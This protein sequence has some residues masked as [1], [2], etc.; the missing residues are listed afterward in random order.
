MTSKMDVLDPSTLPSSDA[1]GVTFDHKSQTVTLPGGIVSV[2]GVTVVTGG[3]EMTWGSC[4][5]ALGFWGTLIGVSVLGL[6]LWDQSNQLQGNTSNLLV[7]GCMILSISV[8]MLG[9]VAL[10][11]LLRK[12]RRERTREE[13]EEGKVVLVEETRRV[14]KRVTKLYANSS[15][16]GYQAASPE[17]NITVQYSRI[18]YKLKI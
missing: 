13:R 6:G 17:H 9:S 16:D 1:T 7:I 5:M 18:Q 3:S 4:M 8:G 10:C 11:Y 14:I 15:Q 12:R 2:A